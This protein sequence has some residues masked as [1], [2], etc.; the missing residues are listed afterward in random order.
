[1]CIEGVPSRSSDAELKFRRII[2]GFENINIGELGT[3]AASN[4]LHTFEKGLHYEMRQSS[5][6]FL[7]VLCALRRVQLKRS[8]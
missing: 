6:C 4:G 1:M 5:S 2:H 3:T 8:E 7:Y